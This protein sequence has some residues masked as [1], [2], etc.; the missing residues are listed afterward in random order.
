MTDSLKLIA[1]FVANP[2]AFAAVA[3]KPE[4]VRLGDYAFAPFVRDGLA[5]A[6][7]ADPPG[8]ETRAKVRVSFEV[9]AS[10]GSG[11]TA[12]VSRELTL[13]G[14]GDATGFDA[15]G[16]IIRREPVPGSRNFEETFLAHVEFDRPDFPWLFSPRAPRG[17]RLDPWLALIVCESAVTR[18][19]APANDLPG[20]IWTKRGQL[21]SLEENW[22]FAHAQVVGAGRAGGGTGALIQRGGGADS[23]QSRLSAAH[24]PANLSRILCPR[25]LEDGTSYVAALVPAFDCGVMIGLGIGGGSLAPAWT[26]A[27]DGS[28]ADGEI[29]L[30]YYDSWEFAT[31]GDGD[32]RSLAEKIRGVAAPWSVGRRRI[33]MSQPGGDIPGLPAGAPGAV[34]ILECALYSPAQA[35]ANA[36]LDPWPA[37][38]REALRVRVDEGNTGTPDLPRVGPRLYAKYQRGAARLGAVFAQPLNA[39]GATEDADADWFLQLNTTPTHRIVAGLGTRVVQKDQEK[40]MQAAWAQVA[41]IREANAALVWAGFAQTLNASIVKRHIEPLELGVLAQITRTVHGR[42]RD[43]ARP[44]SVWAAAES[45]RVAELS[46]SAAFRRQTR[47][48]G[49][50]M[51]RQIGD[52]AVPSLVTK[53]AAFRDHRQTYVNPD[54]ITGLS[55]AGL[56]FFPED[57]IAKVLSVPQAGA[58][59]ALRL[60]IAPLAAKGTAFAQLAAASNTRWE[61]R[62][63]VDAGAALGGILLRQVERTLPSDAPAGKSVSAGPAASILAGL[64]SASEPLRG[65]ATAALTRFNAAAPIQTLNFRSAAVVAAPNPVGAGGVR[66]DPARDLGAALPNALGAAAIR[67]GLRVSPPVTATPHIDERVVRDLRIDPVLID[68][69][70]PVVLGGRGA[71]APAP[72]TPVTRFE[73][74]LS[75]NLSANLSQIT[76]AGAAAL[77]GDLQAIVAGIASPPKVS[78]D[79][80][81]LTVT[82]TAL[83]AELQPAQTALSAFKGRIRTHPDFMQPSWLDVQGLRPIM[84]APVFRRP[85]YEALDDYD[86]DWLIPGLGEIPNRDFVT[87]LTANAAFAETFLIGL[88]DE[89]GRELLWRDYPTDQRGTYFK[90]F[91]DADEDELT[92]QI[93]RFAPQP[94]GR[95]FTMGGT[96]EAGGDRLV[97]VVRGELVRRYPDLVV[98][99]LR[100][101]DAADNVPPVFVAKAEAPILFIAHLRPDY[102]LVGFDLTEAQIRNGN[103]WF[104]LAEQPTAPRFGLAEFGTNSAARDARS[105][106]RDELDW[107]DF[108]L[109]DERF[110]Q[111]SARSLTVTDGFSHPGSLAWPGNSASLARSLLRNPFRAAFRGKTLIESIK[112]AP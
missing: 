68:R 38:Q 76:L 18:V 77:I 54:G 8:A 67:G 15:A 94:L 104:V 2:L 86:R 89:M 24:A 61:A 43:G 105:I 29:V 56:A 3:F 59:N 20:R 42:I 72:D 95:H 83:L 37:R 46:L 78:T 102:V 50:I 41:G 45:S 111:P 93:H 108:P 13:Y 23:V 57:K 63:G 81:P 14:P 65:P 35:P 27:A 49:P 110:L 88:S 39:P 25:R 85:M 100:A 55:E 112:A 26:R 71:P 1:S 5:A 22:R 103:W 73:T 16:Q 21:Q 17:D 84:A 53:G 19:D 28:D 101:Q 7:T 44:R 74:A 48:A 92:E 97:L 79:L 109:R 90:R 64:A 96:A 12:P 34:Q 98:S 40:L 47:A 51:R 33:D 52:A 69:Q 82:R 75:R 60:R 58:R 66:I 30:P 106:N 107:D 32:F 9:A 36:P 99:A 4:D 80:G 31:A 87:L 11:A 10:D 91:W 62:Q 6:I 70:P